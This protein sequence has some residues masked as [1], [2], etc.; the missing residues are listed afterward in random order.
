MFDCGSEEDRFFAR[1]V[2]LSLTKQADLDYRLA[3]KCLQFGSES[4]FYWMIAQACEKYLKSVLLLNDVCVRGINHDIPEAFE[5]IPPH[6]RSVLPDRPKKPDGAP[7]AFSWQKHDGDADKYWLDQSFTQSLRMIS[8]RGSPG[9]RYRE[10]NFYLDGSMVHLFDEIVF[11]LRRICIPFEIWNGQTT[12]QNVSSLR[13]N[14]RLQPLGWLAPLSPPKIRSEYNSLEYGNFAFGQPTDENCYFLDFSHLQGSALSLFVR[15][16]DG[17]RNA[18]QRAIDK[19]VISK[20]HKAIFSEAI[21]NHANDNSAVRHW[22][23]KDDL[24]TP[25]GKHSFFSD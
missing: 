20:K 22:K 3:R 2:L 6:I 5:K 13:N 7:Q 4:H 21:S 10:D 1:I 25:P 12:D 11:Q 9:S 17:A 8:F 15:S 19:G 23:D 16:G 18:L 14:E 24:N